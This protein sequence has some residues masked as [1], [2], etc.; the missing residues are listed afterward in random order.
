MLLEDVFHLFINFFLEE[1]TL[2]E[3]IFNFPN[4]FL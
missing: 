4:T 3:D 1:L 2:S